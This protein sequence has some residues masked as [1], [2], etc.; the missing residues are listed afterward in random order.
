VVGEAGGDVVGS[1]VGVVVGVAVGVAVGVGVDVVE[2]V[3]VDAPT[4]VHEP[5]GIVQLVGDS[6]APFEAPRNPNVTL[7]PEASAVPQEGPA[8]R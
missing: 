8:K 7:A 3:V 1:A 2:E 5:L 4:T 6:G